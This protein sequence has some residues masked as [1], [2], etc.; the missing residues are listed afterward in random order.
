MY[1]YAYVLLVLVLVPVYLRFGHCA[2]LCAFRS[3]YAVWLD[4][5]TI[6]EARERAS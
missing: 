6:N 1:V 3:L 5:H 2:C 4:F